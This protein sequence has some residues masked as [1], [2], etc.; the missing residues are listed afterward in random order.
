MHTLNA[1]SVFAN[2]IL[3]AL[4]GVLCLKHS[5]RA[6][7][8]LSKSVGERDWSAAGGSLAVFGIE[9]ILGMS[10]FN[11]T[12]IFFYLLLEGG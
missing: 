3:L 1:V 6:L 2:M 9:Y 11:G 12:R 10:C 5:V 8:L 4:C 7:G